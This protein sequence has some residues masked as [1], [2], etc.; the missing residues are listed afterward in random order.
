MQEAHKKDG[1]RVAFIKV[2]NGPHWNLL[3]M[4]ND[5]YFCSLWRDS[6]LDILVMRYAAK[7][8]LQ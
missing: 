1:N 7:Y 5:I 8:C 2:D 3:N 4:V 6:G